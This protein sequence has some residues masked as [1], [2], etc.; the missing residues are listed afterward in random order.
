MAGWNNVLKPEEISAMV[1]LVQRWDE[2][3]AGAI[4]APNVPIPTTAESI[5]Q[6]G[7]LFSANCSRCHGPTGQGSQRAPAINVKSVL[8]TTNDQALQ[9]IIT[10]GV[11]G[12]PCPPGAHA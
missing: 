6:G 4:P 3:P 1:T 5:A 9:L 12:P 10:K 7:N 8:T 2:V 11:P